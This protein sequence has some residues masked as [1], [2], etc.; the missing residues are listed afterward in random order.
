MNANELAEQAK[1]TWDEQ[2]V[3]VA[4]KFID[5]ISKKTAVQKTLSDV[6]ETPLPDG[7]SVW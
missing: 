4:G 5:L 1:R 7:Q 6:P 3:D 2:D